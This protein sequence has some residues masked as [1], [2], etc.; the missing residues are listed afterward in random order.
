MNSMADFTKIT[1]KTSDAV[2]LHS[3]LD[4]PGE[5]PTPIL[6]FLELLWTAIL[7]QNHVALTVVKR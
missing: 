1:M 2:F 7:Q 4:E 6:D 3:F 5:L